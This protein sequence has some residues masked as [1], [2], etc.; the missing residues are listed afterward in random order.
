ML[1]YLD[2]SSNTE[3]VLSVIVGILLGS[4]AWWLLARQLSKWQMKK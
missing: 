2:C 3:F 1:K 4:F